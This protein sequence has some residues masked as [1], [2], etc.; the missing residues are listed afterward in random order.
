MAPSGA[1]WPG[2]V[3]PP[4]LG[5][6]TIMPHPHQQ[7]L[8]VAIVGLGNW[9]KN[10]VRVFG[11][12]DRARL[13]ALC[14][15][16]PV[17]L[18]AHTVHPQRPALVTGIDEVLDLEDIQA[19]VIATPPASHAPLGSRAL[20]SGRHVFIEKPMATSV[21]DALDLV[22][23]VKQTGLSLLVGH[24]LEYHPAFEALVT[25]LRSGELGPLCHVSCE[26]RGRG[27]SQHG[28]PWWSLAPH[29]LSL[30]RVL[31][32]SEP[33]ELR[34]SPRDRADTGAVVAHM[35]FPEH[36]TARLEVSA[37]DAERARRVTAVG[38][39]QVAV[40]DDREPVDKLRVFTRKSNNGSSHSDPN[41]LTRPEVLA[42]LDCRVVPFEPAEP[43]WREAE[44]F[45]D[46]VLGGQPVR[47]GP[48]TGLGVVRL[49]EAGQR[50]LDEAPPATQ[51]AAAW[52]PEPP[53]APAT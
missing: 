53:A 20:T 17:R 42:G 6:R 37:V 26:R 36:R 43:L 23:T 51:P 31:F 33:K 41:E 45:V 32:G 7:K 8:G 39:D 40:F 27:A 4:P 21:S 9:G 22:Q 13:V 11:N 46:A 2:A 1:Q 15:R 12:L 35:R 49:L 50:Q 30:V 52:D 3:R 10:L 29:D 14:D 25:L 38:R 16:D 19:V 48:E 24:I 18:A 28:T 5:Q 44:H 34:V 47:T